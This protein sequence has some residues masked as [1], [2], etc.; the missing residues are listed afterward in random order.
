MELSE[1]ESCRWRDD[2]E[3]FRAV[4]EDA[5][6]RHLY[7]F[8][9]EENWPG[10]EKRGG[11]YSWYTCQARGFPMPRPGGSDTSWELDMRNMT[12]D[13]VHLCF[14][15]DHPMYHAAVHEKRL[16][17]PIWL[18]VDLEVAWWKGAMFCDRN[19]ASHNKNMGDRLE[20]LLF[21]DFHVALREKC[22]A[23]NRSSYQA[24]VLVPC[25]VPSHFIHRL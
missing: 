19:A 1:K 12:E 5:G 8:T 21:I 10:I 4:L 2:W 23:D 25:Y 16:R 14:N 22:P 7:H 6:V 3:V 20:D 18:R 17:R 15:R 24:E 11:L 9:D 13:Y